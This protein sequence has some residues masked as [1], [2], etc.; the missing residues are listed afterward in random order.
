MDRG[1]LPATR[2]LGSFPLP[3][4]QFSRPLS[5]R[6][7]TRVL[8]SV[9]LFPS[10]TNAGPTLL[11]P[12]LFLAPQ[13]TSLSLSL[14]YSLP[15]SLAASLSPFVLSPLIS[16]I[17]YTLL[18]S[19]SSISAQ[20]VRNLCAYARAVSYEIYSTR[21]LRGKNSRREGREGLRA[22]KREQES[23]GQKRKRRLLLRSCE[24]VV[25]EEQTRGPYQSL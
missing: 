12:S 1:G 8:L 7:S 3:T 21:R 14:S 2:A 11:S 24:V 25:F 17:S 19:R 13:I 5:P 22:R 6:Y 15:L 20:R 10:R 9:S 16:R 18:L 23:D 4:L